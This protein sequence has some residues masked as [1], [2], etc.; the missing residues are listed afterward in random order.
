MRGLLLTLI[1]IVVAAVVGLGWLVSQVYSQLEQPGGQPHSAYLGLGQQLAKALN[2]TETNSLLQHWPNDGPVGLSLTELGE[3]PLPA[4]LNAKLL[5]GEGVLLEN[6]RHLLINYYVPARQAVLTLTVASPTSS[7]DTSF[8]L[9]LGFYC[10]LIV[11]LLVCLYPL[12]RRL[13]L[14]QESAFAFGAGDLCARI[15][16]SRWSYIRPLEEA[17]NQMAA[18]VQTLLA[19]NRLLSRAVSHDLKT[20]I[21]RLRFGFEMLEEAQ[22]PEQA[23]RY[24]ARIGQDLAAMEALVNRL[25]EYA[26]LEEGQ[27]NLHLQP[28]NLNNLAA[29]LNLSEPLSDG[30]RSQGARP[31]E[32]QLALAPE[33]LWVQADSHYLAMLINNLLNNAQRYCR[34]TIRLSTKQSHQ[35]V[36][37]CISDD[38]PGI[39]VE[40]RAGVLKPFVRGQ[41]HQVQGQAQAQGHG[42]G[43][44]I[45]ERIATWHKA[46]ISLNQDE[47]LGGLAVVITFTAVAPSPGN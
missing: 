17:F 3:F 30:S 16:P 25:L 26:K 14:L 12:V 34:Q 33:D 32:I 22:N 18:R 35:Q 39:P 21:A 45:V 40:E 42:M 13:I 9:T 15:V 44:A 1:A 28:L 11:I 10:G 31:A 7:E 27:I 4:H 24:F 8:T 23:S 19:D 29:Q 5:G 37:L 6:N 2:S 43:L 41:G 38:G 20:P 46:T 36:L 47:T